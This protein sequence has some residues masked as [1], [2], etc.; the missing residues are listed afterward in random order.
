MK[1]HTSRDRDQNAKTNARFLQSLKTSKN[2]FLEET[3]FWILIFLILIYTRILKQGVVMD[4]AMFRWLV[5]FNALF[6]GLYQ[7]HFY[8]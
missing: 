7:C 2:M 6:C 1:F 4:P 5:Y 8:S 3:Y